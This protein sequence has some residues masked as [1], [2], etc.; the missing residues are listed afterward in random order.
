MSQPS[1]TQALSKLESI[2]GMAI[3]DRHARGLRITPEG[4][5]LLPAIQRAVEALQV[6]AKD[7]VEVT[8]GAVGV[9]RIAGISAASTSVLAS[10]M[11]TLML[12]HPELWIEYQ[13]VDAQ[14]I[15]ELCRDDM[16]DLLLCRSSVDVPENYEFVSLLP[17]QNCVYCSYEHPLSGISELTLESCIP[18]T[19]VLPPRDTAS[20][21]AFTQWCESQSVQPKIARIST[22]AFPVIIEMVRK[23]GMLYFGPR[24]HMYPLEAAQLRRLNL[25]V[26]GELAEI[27]YLRR[28]EVRNPAV[29]QVISYLAHW[30]ETSSPTQPS[31]MASGFEASTHGLR[32]LRP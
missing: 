6:L 15:S 26:N 29:R 14:R 27:G 23:F 8:Q 13:E 30:T 5:T 11:P 3:F 7:T 28:C 18:F 21:V 25:Q 2:L 9:V 1:A 10:V 16:A 22:R 24:S 4:A 12:E 31:L 17:D 32:P 20:H 19:W